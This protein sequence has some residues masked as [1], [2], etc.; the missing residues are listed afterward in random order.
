MHYQ[1]G[2]ILYAATELYLQL[3]EQIALDLQAWQLQSARGKQDNY[4][5]ICHCSKSKVLK[6]GPSFFFSTMTILLG[7][8]FNMISAQIDILMPTKPLHYFG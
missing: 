7:L 6:R 4:S 8:H 5:L 2:K 3:S 1:L